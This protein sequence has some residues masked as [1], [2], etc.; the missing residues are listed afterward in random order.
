[1]RSTCSHYCQA[2][3]ARNSRSANALNSVRVTSSPMPLHHH[4]V[5]KFA[6]KL[7]VNKKTFTSSYTPALQPSQEDHQ[8][9]AIYDHPETSDFDIHSNA[10]SVIEVQGQTLSEAEYAACHSYFSGT[11]NCRL[12]HLCCLGL[13]ASTAPELFTLD[14]T[15]NKKSHF[16]LYKQ[17]PIV[18]AM[19]GQVPN[20]T[21]F[22]VASNDKFTVNF[23]PIMG[24]L[25]LI[26]TIARAAMKTHN[27]PNTSNSIGDT[28]KLYA[29]NGLTQT[30]VWSTKPPSVYDATHDGTN[31][32]TP[33]SFDMFS[34]P[35]SLSVISEIPMDG[36]VAMPTFLKIA[37]ADECNFINLQIAGG[38]LF[39]IAEPEY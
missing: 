38:K 11:K 21:S 25:Q 26:H 33:D 37:V 32:L 24:Q 27:A 5:S 35:P 1:M 30:V 19:L 3:I 20:A 14:F 7:G 17:K 2:A 9:S 22:N 10:S 39:L 6:A 15:T 28:L 31:L 4:R 13:L 23:V 12:D 16:I 36:T 34:P 29:A 8:H 18:F